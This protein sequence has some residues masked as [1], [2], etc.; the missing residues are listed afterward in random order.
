VKKISSTLQF[1]PK[2]QTPNNMLWLLAKPDIS[3][4]GYEY[5]MLLVFVMWGLGG[6]W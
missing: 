1:T 3:Q 6:F 2:N 4:N 5:I